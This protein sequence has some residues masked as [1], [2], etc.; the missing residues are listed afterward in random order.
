[1]ISFLIKSS[2]IRR[3]IVCLTPLFLVSPL[4]SQTKRA[5]LVGISGYPQTGT[6]DWPN[7]HGANDVNLLTSTLEQLEFQTK[8][9][10]NDSATAKGIREGIK[11][12]IASCEQGDVVYIH[13]SCH[14]Q[15]VEDINEDE[16]D[17]WDEALVPY[18]A[19]MNYLA[20]QYEGEN[21]ILDD[22]LNMY[23]SAI[24][25]KIG[26]EGIVYAVIDA[27]HAGSSYRGDEK[28]DSIFVRGTNVGF[29]YTGKLFAPKI[30]I[31][32]EF[33][34]ECAPSMANIYILEACRSYENNSEIKQDGMYYG[35][36]S[37]YV[38]LELLTSPLLTD[39]NWIENVRK[40]MDKDT[41]LVRQHMVT[42][43]SR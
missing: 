29:S 37:Y 7:I 31:R 34:V 30:D 1:M 12:F 25:T 22:E 9:Q 3:I 24:R 20:G 38:S 8:V 2:S 13:F 4:Y 40:K 28:E 15:P 21:H 23:L 5:F 32:G 41:R 10:T 35:P 33:M 27:C 19:E 39:T 11:E 14:G 6:N 42:E 18:D 17:G 43:S 26:P 36:L 16:D